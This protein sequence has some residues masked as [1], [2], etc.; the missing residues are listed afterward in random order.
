MPAAFTRKGKYRRI[1]IGF[2]IIFASGY[3]IAGRFSLV[4]IIPIA[5]LCGMPLIVPILQV[6]ALSVGK[7]ET[8]EEDW[9]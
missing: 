5:I 8:V 6:I 9:P 4:K 7:A 2:Q 1:R 3:E